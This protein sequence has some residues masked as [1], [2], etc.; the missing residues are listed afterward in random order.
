MITGGTDTFDGTLDVTTIGTPATYSP[1]TSA[2]G[3]TGE[4]S[5]H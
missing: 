5:G 2:S 4:V 3:N 1:F